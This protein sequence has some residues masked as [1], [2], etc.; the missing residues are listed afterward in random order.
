MANGFQG[1]QAPFRVVDEQVGDQV[2]SFFGRARPEDLAPGLLSDGGELELGI[3]WVHAV[4]LVLRRRAEH[5]DDF[6]ELIDARL[7]GKEGLADE[8]LGDNAANRPDIDGRGVVCRSKDEFGGSVV[9][10]ADV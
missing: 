2:D 8:E 10:R 3:T 9:A 4:D 5:L 1:L 6:D 7:S